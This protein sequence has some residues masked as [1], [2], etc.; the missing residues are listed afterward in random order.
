M[1][2][3]P[4]IWILPVALLALGLAT[5]ATVQPALAA[6]SRLKS[7]DFDED[8][9]EGMNRR[10]LDSLQSIRDRDRKRRKRHLYRKRASFRSEVLRSV[11]ESAFVR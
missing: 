10:P 1:K 2:S 11:G 5:W 8:L 9:V 4:L 6:S 3:K 7:I